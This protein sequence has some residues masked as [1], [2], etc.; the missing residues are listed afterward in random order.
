MKFSS[1]APS[2]DLQDESSLRALNF[3]VV[4]SAVSNSKSEKWKSYWKWSSQERFTIGKYAAINGPTAAKK[5]GSKGWPVNESTIRVFR[6]MFI[7]ELEKARTEKCPIAPNL[8]VL[9][10]G[11][12]LLLGNL[13]QMVQKFLLTLWRRG[14][15]TASVIA[16]SVAKALIARDLHLMLDHIDMDSSTWV[17]NLFHRMS[18]KKWKLLARSKSPMEQRKRSNFCIHMILYLWLTI[19]IFLI[20]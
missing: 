2:Q 6:A 16:V 8:N 12:L 5:F 4:V 9:P 1:I 11:H 18:F 19:I 15:L 13:D 17:K 10:R 7:A 14:G 3:K 20:V